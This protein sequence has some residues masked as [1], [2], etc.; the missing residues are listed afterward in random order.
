MSPLARSRPSLSSWAEWASELAVVVP[1][2]CKNTP[3]GPPAGKEIK[4]EASPEYLL[5]TLT[6][7]EQH[8]GHAF[9]K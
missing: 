7:A 6:W 4:A 2:A 8:R 3:G 1:P 5:Q 9:A